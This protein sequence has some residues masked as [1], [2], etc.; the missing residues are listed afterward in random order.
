MDEIVVKADKLTK[1]YKLYESEMDR[2]KEAFNP[3]KK[4]YHK[5]FFAL[6]NVSFE[7]R[8]GEK[9]G[10]IGSN[11]AGKSTLLKML[12][13]VLT[14]TSGEMNINGKIA[15]LLELGAG[16]NP[17]YTGI[18]NI[19]LNG[20]LL[21]FSQEEMKE[22]MEKIIEFADIGE[23]I[24]QPVKNYSSGMFVRLAFATQIFSDPDVLIVDEALSVGDIRFQQKCYRAMDRLMKDK[25]VLL[26]THDTAA[27]TRF[28]DRVL[29][30]DHGELKFDG[31]VGEG[32]QKYQEYILNKIDEEKKKAAYDEDYYRPAKGNI[33]LKKNDRG[34]NIPEVV[35][36]IKN[37]GNGQVTLTH[38]GLYNEFYKTSD[39]F[40]PGDVFRFIAKVKFN[41]MANRPIMGLGIRDRLGNEVIGINTNTIGVELPALEGEAEVEFTFKLPELNKGGY[42]V[43][44]GIANGFQ[45]DHVQMCWMD[46]VCIFRVPMREYDIPGTIYLQKGKVDVYK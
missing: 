37:K 32:L 20:K 5:S 31:D 3:F 26:V 23:F 30:L 46:D 15:A 41:E 29:W 22:K 42:T 10:I 13:E 43:T 4:S 24:N 35:S 6:K 11:G 21:G 19:N 39:V 8:K 44:V 7:I 38:C 14:A 25:T 28:C 17:D 16:F 33:S 45:D 27:V 40:E 1:E 34:L 36:G 9:V 18:E 2:L 12:T